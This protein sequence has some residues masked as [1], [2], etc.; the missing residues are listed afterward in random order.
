MSDLT[1]KVAW[2]TGGTRGIGKA[3]AGGFTQAGA[4]VIVTGRDESVGQAA[5]A[6][7]GRNARFLAQDVRDEARWQ[8]ILA[9]ILGREGRLDVLVNNAGALMVEPIN[10][11]T[12]E[13][14]ITL[15]ETNVES[16]FL[17][18][19]TAFAGMKAGGSVINVASMLGKVSAPGMAAY[20]ASKGGVLGLTKAAALEGAMDGRNIRVNAILPGLTKTDMAVSFA[21]S[22]A[23]VEAFGANGPL[24][25]IELPEDLVS[26]ALYLAGDGSRYV[27][28]QEIAVEGGSL[29]KAAN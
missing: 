8:A 1:E 28:G 27:T 5:A 18:I 13:K 26:A 24:G 6:A 12:L 25:R 17:G 15:Y 2:I 10:Q 22:E 20:S 11:L 14:F 3:I 16:C 21:G 19:R 9:D 4:R 7:L 29:A 23:A